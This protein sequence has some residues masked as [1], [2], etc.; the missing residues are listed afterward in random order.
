IKNFTFYNMITRGQSKTNLTINLCDQIKQFTCDVKKW[1]GLYSKPEKI[2]NNLNPISK[3]RKDKEIE[4][5][6]Q[7]I[8]IL[9]LRQYEEKENINVEK[10]IKEEKNLAKELKLLDVAE[11]LLC[12]TPKKKQSENNKS[13]NSIQNNSL[14]NSFINILGFNFSEQTVNKV[15][16]FIIL[17][18]DSKVIK[19]AARKNNLMFEGYEK[20]E[21]YRKNTFTAVTTLHK[22]VQNIKEP[23]NVIL[24]IYTNVDELI[25]I[26]SKSGNFNKMKQLVEKIEEIFQLFISYEILFNLK[27]DYVDQSTNIEKFLYILNVAFEL[28]D[29]VLDRVK[30]NVLTQR[31]DQATLDLL[32]S[33]EEN[34]TYATYAEKLRVTFP[35]A[36]SIM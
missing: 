22:V 13:K 2:T 8:E 19:Y 20:F 1:K 25:N 28:Y 35:S 26:N 24:K 10:N 34:E 21:S 12:S 30:I 32:P 11:P 17:D 33:I 5:L 18:V 29:V 9:C 15:D 36:N 7:E 23:E 31:I 3:K 6:K 16:V 27:D 14:F 4:I